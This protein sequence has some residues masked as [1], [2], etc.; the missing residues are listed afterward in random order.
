M[1]SPYDEFNGRHPLENR[2]IHERGAT[3]AIEAGTLP[4]VR[5][6]NPATQY[7]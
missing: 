2:A 7:R 3:K 5:I 6:G 1:V 4:P